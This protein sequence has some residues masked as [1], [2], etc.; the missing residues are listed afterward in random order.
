MTEFQTIGC[1]LSMFTQVELAALNLAA[2]DHFKAGAEGFAYLL[3]Q[4]AEFEMD[5]RAWNLAHPGAERSAVNGRI[6]L[7][8]WSD[9][10]IADALIVCW[11]MSEHTAHPKLG[12]LFDELGNTFATIA[13]DRLRNSGDPK[14]ATGFADRNGLTEGPRVNPEAN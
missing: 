10:D 13:A 5:R 8:H 11:G 3:G 14:N 4:M 9:A 1:P 2:E 12:E 6:R 7:S